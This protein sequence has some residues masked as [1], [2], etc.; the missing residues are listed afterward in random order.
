M[1]KLWFKVL[2]LAFTL[3]LLSL[4]FVG[5]HLAAKWLSE[6]GKELLGRK[7]EAGSIGINY[8]N[9]CITVTNVVLY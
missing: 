5:L 9:A 3:L 4:H 6:N 7:L 2:L 8:L 1:K